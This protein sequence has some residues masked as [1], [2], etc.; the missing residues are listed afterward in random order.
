V[1]QLQA[2]IYKH[3]KGGMYLIIGVARHSET[4]E[5][6][7]AYIPLGVK[8]GPRIVARPYDMFFDDVKINGVTKPRFVYIGES[9]EEV[10]AKFY[11]P[12][13]GYTGKDRVND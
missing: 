10:F 6:L 7:V 2:G 5:K 9:V 12:M 3:Y 11:D 4:N 8:K 1:N 13:S